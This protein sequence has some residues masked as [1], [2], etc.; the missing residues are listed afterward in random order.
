M[1]KIMALLLM[2]ILTLSL[3]A[4]AGGN[5]PTPPPGGITAPGDD[6]CACCPDCSRGANCEYDCKECDCCASGG[7]APAAI[8]Y[9]VE[10]EMEFICTDPACHFDGCGATAIGS[11]RVETVWDESRAA[12]RGS[13]QGTGAYESYGQHFLGQDK[14]NIEL[15]RADLLPI[16]NFTVLLLRDDKGIKVGIDRFGPAEDTVHGPVWGTSTL[17]GLL[18]SY[19]SALTQNPLPSDSGSYS[20]DAND[21]CLYFSLP[22]ANAQES[23]TVHFPAGTFVITIILV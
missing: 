13:A 18:H 5:N 21:D 16:F 22:L 8:A 15:L 23:F 6:P 20:Y 2:A 17:P 1:K 14:T 11:A 3:S 9:Y 7:P 19:Y 4:C 10:I 12:H